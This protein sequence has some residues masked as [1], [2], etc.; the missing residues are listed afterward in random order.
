MVGNSW[1]DK[2]KLIWNSP[3]FNK[4]Y[5]DILNRYET[6]VVFPD[7]QNIFNALKLTD[8]DNVKDVA[9]FITPVPGGVGPMTIAML[10]QNVLKAA[11]NFE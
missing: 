7:K 11:E 9:G 1:D 10:L 4:F 3:G 2:L 6:S 5:N 8:F